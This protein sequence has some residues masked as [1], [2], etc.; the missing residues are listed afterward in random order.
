[1]QL[2]IIHSLQVKLY[3]FMLA[4]RVQVAP[5]C[6]LQFLLDSMVVE[7][8]TTARAEEQQVVVV[9]QI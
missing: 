6:L 2:G 3:M 5:V 1:M 9:G 7:S 8:V 4:V